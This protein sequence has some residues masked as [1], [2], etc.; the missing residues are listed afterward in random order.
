MDH[1]VS[2]IKKYFDDWVESQFK[3]N[4]D[5]SP[6]YNIISKHPHSD[7]KKNMD[8]ET[9]VDVAMDIHLTCFNQEDMKFFKDDKHACEW[10]GSVENAFKMIAWVEEYEM[11]N[12]DTINTHLSNP[13]STANSYISYKGIDEGIAMDWLV[14]TSA[15]AEYAKIDKEKDLN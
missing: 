5:K 6:L 2:E 10:I 9:M 8:G 15:A 12:F 13:T 4:K 14:N 3:M 1:K 7:R 11:E